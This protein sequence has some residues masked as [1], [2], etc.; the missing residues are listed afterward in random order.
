MYYLDKWM[1]LFILTLF[2]LFIRCGYPCAHVLK[3][4]NELTVKMIKV[5]CWKLY[6]THYNDD[7]DTLGISL[8]L[9]KIQF[10]YSNNEG[11][12][13]PIST[14]ILTRSWRPFYDDLFPYFYDRT[15]LDDYQSALALE[16]TGCCVTKM[17]YA[18]LDGIRKNIVSFL[19]LFIQWIH[20]IHDLFIAWIHIINEFIEN[21]QGTDDVSHTSNILKEAENN[22]I[23]ETP[24]KPKKNYI[25]LL[26]LC[27]KAWL[28]QGHRFISITSN[29]QISWQYRKGNQVV[30]SGLQ[31]TEV[32]GGAKE[33]D[34]VHWSHS[35]SRFSLWNFNCS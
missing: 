3:V 7:D 23:L 11:M 27:S 9:K 21:N 22:V 20:L 1:T 19:I 25:K 8:E 15:T 26:T 34:W 10:K 31:I 4:T 17:E 32:E 35:K 6:A 18:N 24:Q 33:Y 14:E 16:R 2:C 28:F 13:V 29:T 30:R 5:Q 12:G